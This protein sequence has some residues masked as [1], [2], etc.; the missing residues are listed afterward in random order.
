MPERF[1]SSPRAA[2]RR[3]QLVEI[4]RQSMFVP[5]HPPEHIDNREIEMRLRLRAEAEARRNARLREAE[6][7]SDERTL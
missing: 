6:T 7:V 1:Q 4:L 5:E 3:G 2:T